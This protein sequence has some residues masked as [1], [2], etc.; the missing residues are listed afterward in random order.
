MTLNDFLQLSYAWA[1]RQALLVL[2]VAVLI[3]IV[4]TALAWVGK[5]GRTDADGRFIASAVVA[6]AFLGVLVELAAIF[7]ARAV[8]G[9]GVF[10]A[11]LL[12][13]LAPLLCLA[14]SLLGI[15]LVFP[16]SELG[17]IRTALDVGLFVV[18]CGAVLWFL[19]KFRGWG[20]VF[21][22]GLGQLLLLGVVAAFFL[23]RLYRRAFGRTRPPVEPRTSPEQVSG[24]PR[25]PLAAGLLALGVVAA[26]GGVLAGAYA[27][28][29]R[30]GGP[31]APVGG[32]A[33]P[34]EKPTAFTYTDARGI[35]HFV[36]HLEDVPAE[37]RSSAKPLK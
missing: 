20:I 8:H 27:W 11:N 29:A 28:L 5:G 33:G 6:L 15:R 13:L 4:G 34:G 19:S 10:D 9:V 35:Q 7:V 37:F 21:F 12:L 32:P 17:S 31:T 22:G 16:L 3:P 25:N 36:S 14:G 2:L 18:A 26:T 30:T 24:G 1:D 23:W